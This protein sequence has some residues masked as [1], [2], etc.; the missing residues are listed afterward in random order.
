MTSALVV[1]GFAMT[2]IRFRALRQTLH[3][4]VMTV[5]AFVCPGPAVGQPPPPASASVSDHDV[6][7]DS[8]LGR[9][10]TNLWGE[11]G[12]DVRRHLLNR[13]AADIIHRRSA[14]GSSLRD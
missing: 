9:L 1:L 5:A 3:A 10:A 4:I 2:T 7:R 12:P 11:F 13:P 6:G 8:I 14:P